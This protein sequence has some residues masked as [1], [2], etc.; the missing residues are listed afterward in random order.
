MTRKIHCADC[1]IN[2]T[3]LPDD[4]ALSPDFKFTCK[5]CYGP[6]NRVQ[7]L[8]VAHDPRLER[9]GT[10]EGTAASR[11]RPE[12]IAHEEFVRAGFHLDSRTPKAM[13]PGPDWCYSDAFLRE[14]LIDRTRE[15]MG[16]ALVVIVGRW[17]RGLTFK[18][19][20][21]ETNQPPA[22]VRKGLSVFRTEGNALW[23]KHQ[24]A[25]AK[26]ERNRQLSVR[27]HE[28]FALGLSVRQVAEILKCSV[29]RASEL[30]QAA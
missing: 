7:G 29:G 20:A 17:R 19:L 14:L 9:A 22:E 23:E 6:D 27:A 25:E 21:E 1:G 28:L 26:A 2:S 16:R 10:P 5:E 3:E 24:R 8:T 15:E 11:P 4:A 18:E 12:Q 30:R 13:K